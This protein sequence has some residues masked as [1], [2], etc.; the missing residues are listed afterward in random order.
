MITF[1][2]YIEKE[3][4]MSDETSL[5]NLNE[6]KLGKAAALGFASKH[7]SNRMKGQSA[8]KK[9]A[10]SASKIKQTKDLGDK[11]NHLGDSIASLAESLVRLMD[12][13]G[14]NISVGVA[15]VL[16]S[17]TASKEVNRLLNRKKR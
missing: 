9:A 16:T 6:S 17:E 15:S 3:K 5:K 1:K 8:A 2:E 10:A 14:D 7:R 12:M 4:N 13:S 11:L